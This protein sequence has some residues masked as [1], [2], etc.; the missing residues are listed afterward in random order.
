MTKTTNTEKIVKELDTL[1]TIYGL[2]ASIATDNVPQ[3]VNATFKQYMEENGIA[4]GRITPLWSS[5]NCKIERQNRSLLK[6]MNITNAE[7]KPLEMEVL[8]VY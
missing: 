5:A 8:T 3:F 7:K 6:S 1:F 2:P 4:H